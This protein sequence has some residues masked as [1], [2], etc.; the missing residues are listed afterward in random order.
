MSIKDWPADERPREKLLNMGATS[1]SDAELL[2]IFLRTGIAGSSAV[3]LARQLLNEFG[4]LRQLLD[5]DQKL[6]CASKG[7][8]S[9]KYAQLQAVIEMARRHF[10]QTIERQ[11]ALKNSSDTKNYLIQ[12]LRDQ[13]RE[14]FGVLLLDTRH[15]VI[16]YDH[17]FFGGLSSSSV[18]PRE[19]VKHALKHN[20]AAIIFAHNHPS[21]VAEPSQAD[22]HL[23]QQLSA[24]LKTVDV[25]TLDHIIVG[26][27]YC[28]SLAEHGLI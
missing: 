18:H 22:I 4:G 2:A 7:L 12:Q 9:A 20:A 28:E 27:S 24:A 21:G 6:F 1:L 15:R 17:L 26:D 25:R 13:P 5:A 10:A 14:V 3:D 16:R 23:T 8:G 19:V 11:D